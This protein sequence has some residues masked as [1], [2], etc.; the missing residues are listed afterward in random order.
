MANEEAAI[1]QPKSKK[2]LIIA[3]V[4]VVNVVVIGGVFFFLTQSSSDRDAVQQPARQ[5]RPARSAVVNGPIIELAGFVVNLNVGNER[6]YL[7]TK[8]SLQLFTPEDV[9]EFEKFRS[10]VRNEILLQLSEVEMESV[11]TIE[12][13]RE[14]EKMLATKVNERLDV[15]RVA[16]VYLTEFVTQ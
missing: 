5:N 15:D 9:P 13:K 7:K 3:I 16:Y 1:E 14:L 8:M 12:G 10:I 11:K 2:G 6:K 4:V